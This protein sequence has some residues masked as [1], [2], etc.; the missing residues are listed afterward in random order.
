MDGAVSEVIHVM[1]P[2]PKLCFATNSGIS[3]AAVASVGQRRLAEASGVSLAREAELH[4]EAD[5][6]A[7]VVE[8]GRLHR[9][10]DLR[11]AAA[12]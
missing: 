11:R 5:I 4:V 3:Q 8:D 1:S 10:K 6:P 2:T 7:A 9:P 12:Q